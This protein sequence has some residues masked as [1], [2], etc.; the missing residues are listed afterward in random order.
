[1]LGSP[2]PVPSACPPAVRTRP[3]LGP[4]QPSDSH[5]LALQTPQP[6]LY[7][8]PPHG[9][10]PPPPAPQMLTPILGAQRAPF[11]PPLFLEWAGFANQP[12]RNSQWR[13]SP[14]VLCK[15]MRE[16][17][18][19]CKCCRAVG[20]GSGQRAAPGSAPAPDRHRDPTA[21]GPHRAG[22]AP[23]QRQAPA[24]VPAETYRGEGA[25]VQVRVPGGEAGSRAHGGAELPQPPV[26]K[27]GAGAEPAA[28]TGVREGENGR[29]SPSPAP[30]RDPSVPAAP[31]RPPRRC[32]RAGGGGGPV[33]RGVRC[34]AVRPGRRPAGCPEHGGAPAPA[35]PSRDGGL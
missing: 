8:S 7:R 25:G 3:P 2:N 23:L 13:A 5:R 24:A 11:A 18:G 14:A 29:R 31:Q 27:P 12:R 20:A 15:F 4:T 10:S 28:G 30:R 6:H 35:P 9:C 34:G 22:P 1:M 16:E 17:A 26:G 21:A 19:L 32:A 33:W